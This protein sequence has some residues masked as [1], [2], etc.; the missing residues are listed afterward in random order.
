[1]TVYRTFEK[2]EVMIV[3][4]SISL[5]LYNEKRFRH[6]AGNTVAVFLKKRYH[7]KFWRRGRENWCLDVLH[8]IRI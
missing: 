3:Y 1:M 5:S 7:R 8:E 4:V 2:R 6:T